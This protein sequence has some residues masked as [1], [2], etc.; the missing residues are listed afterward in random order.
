MQQQRRREDQQSRPPSLQRQRQQILP[1]PPENADDQKRD[2]IAVTRIFRGTG[3]VVSFVQPAEQRRR[4]DVTEDG[5]APEL[6]QQEPRRQQREEK[7]LVRQAPPAL[8]GVRP[9]VRRRCFGLVT[10]HLCV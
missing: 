4:V 9:P 2:E 10:V 1:F 6:E 5:I 3:A 8:D 7:K